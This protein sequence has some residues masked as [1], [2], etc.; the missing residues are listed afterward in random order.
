MIEILPKYTIRDW[1]KCKNIC[2]SMHLD[3]KITKVFNRKGS[4]L[5]IQKRTIGCRTCN[6]TSVRT[7]VKYGTTDYRKSA[8]KTYLH[9]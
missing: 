1:D 7:E 6:I 5:L 8:W 9:S 4:Y 3:L 2:H